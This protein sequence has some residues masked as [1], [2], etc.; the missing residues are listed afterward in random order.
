MSV[1]RLGFFLLK[2]NCF[3]KKESDCVSEEDRQEGFSFGGVARQESV[4]FSELVRQESYCV[5]EVEQQKIVRVSEVAR[6]FC[7]VT[8]EFKYP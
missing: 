4:S 3:P 6:Q 1:F 5:S 8:G 2:K 7:V